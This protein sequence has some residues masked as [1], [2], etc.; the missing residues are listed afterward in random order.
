MKNLNLKINDIHC[1]SC[2]KLITMGLEDLEGIGK[3][4]ID[5][6]TKTAQVEFDETKTNQAEILKNIEEVGYQGEVI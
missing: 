5:P 6:K 4:Q 1:Q 3:I 2:V